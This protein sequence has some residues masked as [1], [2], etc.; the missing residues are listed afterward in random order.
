MQGRKAGVEAYLTKPFHPEELKYSVENLLSLRDDIKK[1]AFAEKKIAT[2]Q[3]EF[4]QNL[5]GLIDREL[6]NHELDVKM[7]TRELAVSRTQLHRK[8]KS[9]TGKSINQFVREYRLMKAKEMLQQKMANV[10]EVCYDVGFTHPSYFA[11]RFKEFFGEL[12]S[13]V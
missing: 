7:I 4:M 3:D 1:T 5:Q 10:S 6:G 9:I 11:A 8:V 12:P 13:E 2:F